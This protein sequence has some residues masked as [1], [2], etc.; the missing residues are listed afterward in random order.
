[1]ECHLLSPSLISFPNLHIP[2][3]ERGGEE[4]DQSILRRERERER[5]K[6]AKLQDG[7]REKKNIFKG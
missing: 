2:K 3:R 5:E 4:K 7:K 1:M 6:R